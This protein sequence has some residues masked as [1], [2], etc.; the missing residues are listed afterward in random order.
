MNLNPGKARGPFFGRVMLAAVL[1]QAIL[2]MG[3]PPLSAAFKRVSRNE[4][5]PAFSLE[6]LDGKGWK[7]GELYPGK[8]T[9]VVFWATWSP[10]SREILEDLEKLRRELGDERV[11]VIAVN[12]EH[13]EIS[14]SDQSAIRKV[15]DELD[16]AALVLLDQG[17]VA[18]NEY[19]AM[20]LPSSLVVDVKGTV[21]FDLAGYPTTMRS[22][23]A[24]AVRKA[25]GLPTSE[26]LRPPE[27]YVPKNRALMFYNFGKRLMEKGQE[28]K[29]EA[30]LLTAVERDPDFVKPRVLLG[31][32]F[33][34]T[35]RLDEAMEQFD[36]IREVDPAN[37]EASYQAAS[38]SLR[39]AR[40]P[41]AEALLGE[42]HEEF[43]E[44][45]EFALGLAL[46][47]KYQGR[48][49]EYRALA[50]RA[51]ALLPPAA[52]ILYDLGGVAEGQ[53]DLHVAAPLYRRAIEGSLKK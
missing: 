52:H 18:Y 12:A 51:S 38:V 46:A 25:L 4:P 36:R 53:G 31:I 35:G 14:S 29:G 50:E 11:Q 23:L 7:S 41:E 20:A 26:E 15:V 33:K 34:K 47:H 16:L 48:E 30:Q 21:T 22:D 5:P 17:L 24:D 3:S 44:R 19:G 42:L 39:A 6:D 45:E 27:E 32:Y 13:T 43:P 49:E 37:E 10:R 1:L 40:F 28:E 9:V 8:V 2:W